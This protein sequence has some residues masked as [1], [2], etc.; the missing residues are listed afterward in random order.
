MKKIRTILI[1]FSIGLVLSLAPISIFAV[2]DAA[3]LERIGENWTICE[4]EGEYCVYG[5]DT[6]YCLYNCGSIY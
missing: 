6:C 1:S 3:I 2:C 5:T 4:L